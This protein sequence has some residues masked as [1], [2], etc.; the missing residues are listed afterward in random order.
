M[1]TWLGLAARAEP[2]LEPTAGGAPPRGAGGHVVLRDDG[3]AVSCQQPDVQLIDTRVQPAILVPGGGV[4][5]FSCHCSS[6]VPTSTPGL[7]EGAGRPV[8]GS[9]MLP[10]L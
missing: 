7:S 8:I 1:N 9:T 6:R 5:A 2:H 10:G 4:Q 3:P